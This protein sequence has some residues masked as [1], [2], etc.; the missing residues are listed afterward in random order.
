MTMHAEPARWDRWRVLLIA[1]Q[2]GDRV[3]YRNLLHEI[4]RWLRAPGE[5]GPIDEA[6]IPRVLLSLHDLRH[7]Y[8]ARTHET[9]R[10]DR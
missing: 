10:F 4:T 9:P 8:Q 3:A 1:A 5:L 2:D 7:T 6:V